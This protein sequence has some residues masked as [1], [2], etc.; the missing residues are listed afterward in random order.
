MPRRPKIGDLFEI[1]TSKGMAYGQYCHREGGEPLG[2]GPLIRVIE[3]LHNRRPTDLQVIAR[4]PTL[5]WTYYPL[6]AALN[7]GLVTNLG[8]FPIPAEAAEYPVLRSR[9]GID[10]TG[11]VYDWNILGRDTEL[12][13]TII[14]IVR[15]LNREEQR[16]SEAVIVSHPV[17]IDRIE[18][19]YRPETDPVML[20]ANRHWTEATTGENAARGRANGLEDD[21][22][23]GDCCS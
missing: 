2:A 3:G 6:G 16:L 10:R 5:F 4:Q 21:R 13:A 23:Q 12:R 9:R 17:L 1:E 14:R 8:T 15:I 18:E 22:T 20:R 19:Q 7:Q 11:L